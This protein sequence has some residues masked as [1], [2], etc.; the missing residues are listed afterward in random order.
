ML[1]KLVGIPVVILGGV[2][3][4]SN[5]AGCKPVDFGLRKFDLSPSPNLKTLIIRNEMS[6]DLRV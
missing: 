1:F 6:L 3:K 5:G 2:P 4:Q